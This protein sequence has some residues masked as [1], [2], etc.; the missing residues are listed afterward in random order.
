MSQLKSRRGVVACL[1]AMLM[2][3]AALTHAADSTRIFVSDQGNNRVLI[4]NHP[5]ND[6][7]VGTALGA[8]RVSPNSWKATNSTQGPNKSS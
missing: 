6:P 1:A 7:L 4:Y 3:G 8:S 2:S 5:T